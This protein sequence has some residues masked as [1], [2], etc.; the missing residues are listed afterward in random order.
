M[1]TLLAILLVIFGN[2]ADYLS[3]L[4]ALGRGARE[5]NPLIARVGLLPSKLTV[6]GVLS[7]V[8][9]VIGGLQALACAVLFLCGYALLALHN[10]KSAR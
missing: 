10:I 7:M 2:G 4:Y 1:L 3:T 5:L 6:T 8:L 9:W